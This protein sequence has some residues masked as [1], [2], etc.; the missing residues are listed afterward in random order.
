MLIFRKTFLKK[1]ALNCVV[2]YRNQFLHRNTTKVWRAEI[3]S[4]MLSIY[5]LHA[6]SVN[7]FWYDHQLTWHSL[8]RQITIC[9]DVSMQYI[10][11]ITSTQPVK[12]FTHWS[13]VDSNCQHLFTSPFRQLPP[14]FRH[15]SIDLPQKFHY[16]LV[17]CTV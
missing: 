6:L 2:W 12:I 1:W 4:Q 5:W 14:T 7:P 3:I 17:R 13:D 8:I 16:S 11:Y 10:Q 15:R 9:I